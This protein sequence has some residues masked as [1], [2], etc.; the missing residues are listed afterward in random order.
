MGLIEVCRGRQVYLDTNI[1]IYA[2][3]GLSEHMPVLRPLFELF[4]SG[5]ASAVTSELTLAEVLPRPLATGCTD[6]AIIY[7]RMLATSA[8]L[9]MVPVSRAILV[10]AA[11]LRASSG[12]RLPDAIHV[13]T[14]V[15][16]GCS[17]LLSNDRRLKVPDALQLLA[18]AGD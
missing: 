7:E 11:H 2:V 3:E 4:A 15:A 1:F 9:A 13:A 18:L 12:L 14:A 5:G 6:I 17:V 8:W 10:D 16:A